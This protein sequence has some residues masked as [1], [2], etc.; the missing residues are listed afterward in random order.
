MSTVNSTKRPSIADRLITNLPVAT[1]TWIGLRPARRENMISVDSVIALEGLGLEGDRRTKGRPGTA[2]QV[3]F[4]SEE[5]LN[6]VATLLKQEHILPELVRR[7]IVLSG[8][9]INALRYKSFQIGEA[10]FQ[11]SAYCPPCSRMDENLGEHGF[12]SMLGHGGI[13]AK[14]VK[15]GNSALITLTQHFF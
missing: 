13:C 4:I 8:I 6:V 9:N 10:V 3:T 2:R 5:H 11:T 14:I 7:N 15:T 12:A 1:V